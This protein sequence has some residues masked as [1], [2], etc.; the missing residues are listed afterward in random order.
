MAFCF[1]SIM[2]ISCTDNSTDETVVE[3]EI[4]AEETESADEKQDTNATNTAGVPY[5]LNGKIGGNWYAPCGNNTQ[6]FSFTDSKIYYNFSYAKG[7]TFSSVGYFWKADLSFLTPD[8]SEFDYNQEGIASGAAKGHEK[9]LV[10]DK[11]I[12]VLQNGFECHNSHGWTHI[13][14][15]DLN[16][17]NDGVPFMGFGK[18][19]SNFFGDYNE[20][21]VFT[22]SGNCYK[23]YSSILTNELLILSG[24]WEKYDEQ[25]YK[26]YWNKNDKTRYDILKGTKLYQNASESI[27][28]VPITLY[29][30]ES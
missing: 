29:V 18:T 24:T 10:L 20:W 9:I 8:L 15:K 23:R 26:I 14:Y 21:I 1:I 5:I 2:L 28:S 4:R 11:D 3:R 17:Y 12:L 13:C 27:D 25:S 7:S 30:S 16:A 22:P 19:D 6:Y